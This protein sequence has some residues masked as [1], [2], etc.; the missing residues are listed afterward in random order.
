[1]ASLTFDFYLLNEIVEI[2][3]HLYLYGVWSPDL[4]NVYVP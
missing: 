4:F 3:Q 2:I 1:M